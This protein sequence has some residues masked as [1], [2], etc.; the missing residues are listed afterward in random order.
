MVLYTQHSKYIC[1]IWVVTYAHKCTQHRDI[2][3]LVIPT[4]NLKS[5]ELILETYATS[6]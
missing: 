1:H 6:G 4:G 2:F 5:S 3:V